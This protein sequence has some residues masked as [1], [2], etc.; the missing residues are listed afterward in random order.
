M[1]AGQE[2]PARVFLGFL[3]A[4]PGIRSFS[5]PRPGK[6]Y[7]VLR[8][9]WLV[10][11][12]V[13]LWASAQAQPLA[14]LAQAEGW[15]ALMYVPAPAPARMPRLAPVPEGMPLPARGLA[16]VGAHESRADTSRVR[17]G[18][19]ALVVGTSAALYAGSMA[20]L[21]FVWYKGVPRVPFQF[22]HDLAGY[23][24]VDKMGHLY[25]AYLQSYLGFHSLVWS[26]VP[27]RKAIWYG[28]SYGFFMQL[29]I[30]IWDGLYEG[31][32]FS[33]SDVAA[34]TLGAGLVI[35]QELA[36]GEQVATYKFSFRPSPYA[37]QANGY[38]GT[39][40]NQ[41]FYDY[42]G[43]TYWLSIGL[44]RVLPVRGL[45]RWLNLAV[46][47]GAGGM[48]GEFGNL[49][50]YRGV[51]IPPT[52]RYRR[53]MLSL[54]VDFGKIKTRNRFLKTLF[55]AMFV[56]KVPLPTLEL[57]TKGQV[58]LHPLYY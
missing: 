10:L 7:F 52:E 14:S 34:N 8:P 47:Y 32:G 36:F 55:K 24:Q 46:G 54:D 53:F 56:V 22:Y 45:P 39:G 18:R 11:L 31:W 4:Q 6:N 51:D 48:F 17:R 43:H 33:W 30:E 12:P 40:F 35:G 5:Q 25:G 23:N 2:N 13:L 38:L 58:R 16:Q 50:R 28:G 42:N 1:A 44:H 37:R 9:C 20:Y 49:A 26:G 21:Q 15:A 3:F 41:L 27:R 29:P 57:N 19:L